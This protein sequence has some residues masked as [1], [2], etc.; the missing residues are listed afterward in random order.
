MIAA[1][2]WYLGFRIRAVESRTWGS[3]VERENVW[4]VYGLVFGV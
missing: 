4:W 2:T 1:A 3:R